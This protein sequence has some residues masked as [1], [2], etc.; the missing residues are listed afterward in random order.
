M[1]HQITGTRSVTPRARHI[2][3]LLT[4]MMLL[5]GGVLLAPSN[6][7]GGTQQQDGP[8]IFGDDINTSTANPYPAIAVSTIQTM[9][10]GQCPWINTGLATFLAANPANGSGPSGEAWTF[11]WAGAAQEAQVEAGITT[12][13]YYPW[14]I[15]EPTA[16]TANGATYAGDGL[17]GERGGAV[18]NLK[19]IPQPGAPAMNNLRWIQGLNG[20]IRGTALATGLDNFTDATFTT[21]DN[22]S[23]FYDG[24]LTPGTAGTLALT[25]PAQPGRGQGGWF[26]DVPKIN[27]NEYEGSPVASVQF[28]VIL[29]DDTRTLGGNGVWQNAV[30]LYGGVWWG[31]EYTASDMGVPEP[32]TYVL[33]ILGGIGLLFVRRKTGKKQAA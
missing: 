10:P 33:L 5:A 22:S 15:S 29:A 13:D 21:R 18:L 11:T 27:E 20:T 6:A 16:Y 4:A 32:A 23:P 3:P 19:Y 14:V 2:V 28:Q 9:P 1:R 30:T 12:I 8:R 24:G 7:Y 17:M 25:N 31:F 26:L